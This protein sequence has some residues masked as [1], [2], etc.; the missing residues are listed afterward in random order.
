VTSRTRIPSRASMSIRVSVLKRSIRPLKRSLT[1]GC[2]TRRTLAAWGCLRPRSLSTFSIW[3][4]RSA[5]IRRCSA[6]S[7]AK[8]RSRKTLPLDRA[9]LCL[10]FAMI[11]LPSLLQQ[12]PISALRE[13]YVSPWGLPTPLLESVKHINA[14]GKPRH[15]EKTR[16]S[17]AVWTRISST[18][19]PTAGIHF[20]SLGS[21]PCWTRRSWKPAL[22]R[23]WSGNALTSSREDPSQ[24]SGLSTPRHYTSIYMLNQAW[25][26]VARVCATGNIGNRTSGVH[27]SSG[28]PDT[29]QF[30]PGSGRPFHFLRETEAPSSV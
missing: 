6:S 2:V 7:E 9:N 13:L 17:V 19:A 12:V 14:L 20:Q 10:P 18:P 29:R 1:R 28:R 8:P 3:I 11:S 16:C 30:D 21:S 24:K 15:V 26:R 27:F 25:R 23:A 22:L 5:R 4:I